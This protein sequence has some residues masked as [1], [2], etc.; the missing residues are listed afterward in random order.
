MKNYSFRLLDDDWWKPKFHTCEEWSRL[1]KQV[2][3]TSLNDLMIKYGTKRVKSHYIPIK[4]QQPDGTEKEGYW[5]MPMSL[6]N[7]IE[8]LVNAN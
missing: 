1:Q 7:K 8:E 6:C 2:P 5:Q 3:D 4:I